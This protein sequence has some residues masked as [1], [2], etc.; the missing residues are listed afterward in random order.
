MLPYRNFRPMG[1]RLS[2]THIVVMQ[3]AEGKGHSCQHS[4]FLKWKVEEADLKPKITK[5]NG[6]DMVTEVGLLCCFSLVVA[7]LSRRAHSLIA[8][9]RSSPVFRKTHCYDSFVSRAR[10]DDWWS[11]KI[12]PLGVNMRIQESIFLRTWVFYKARPATVIL[13]LLGQDCVSETGP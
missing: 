12:A 10:K 9:R 11:D 8:H 4:T 2:L 13:T 1:M 5:I 6:K 7:F 3:M